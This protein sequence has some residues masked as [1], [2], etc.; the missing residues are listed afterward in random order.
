MFN[1]KT[2][3]KRK[4]KWAIEKLKTGEFIA[5]VEPLSSS[6]GSL[7]EHLLRIKRLNNE[8]PPF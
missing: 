2:D 4:K 3:I 5:T 8:Y 1:S 7:W 6:H